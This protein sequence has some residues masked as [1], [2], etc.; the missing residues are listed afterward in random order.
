MIL[1]DDD[2]YLS[3]LGLHRIFA[4]VGD[5]EC[6]YAAFLSRRVPTIDLVVLGTRFVFHLLAP[7]LHDCR[8]LHGE[9]RCVFI[10]VWFGR[11]ER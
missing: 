5:A 11:K 2:N 6:R 3:I 10:V 4:Q 8:A 7:L 9:K 1:T